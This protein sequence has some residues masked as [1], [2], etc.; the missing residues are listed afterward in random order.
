[1]SD[2][3]RSLV[4]HYYQNNLILGDFPLQQKNSKGSFA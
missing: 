3:L 2:F 1:M 4:T